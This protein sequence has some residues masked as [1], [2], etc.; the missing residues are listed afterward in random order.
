MLFYHGRKGS[1]P[2]SLKLIDL[3]EN[4]AFAKET[5]FNDPILVDLSQIP[6]ETFATH[7]KLGLLEMVQQHLFT[8]DLKEIAQKLI[9]LVI[10]NPPDHESFTSLLY[11]MLMEGDTANIHPVIKTL[12]SIKAYKEDVMNAAQQLRQ[13]GLAQGLEQGRHLEAIV[14][15]KNMLVEGMSLKAVQKLTGLSDNEV[16]ALVEKH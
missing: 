11:Y 13:E 2:Y 10:K 8:R 15:A 5:F 7:R 12:E 16:M 3:F 1:Y 14:I 9:Q 4:K 6:D